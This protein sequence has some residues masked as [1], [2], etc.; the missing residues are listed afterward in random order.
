[1]PRA[2][3][4]KGFVFRVLPAPTIPKGAASAEGASEENWRFCGKYCAKFILKCQS[5]A[6]YSQILGSIPDSLFWHLEKL[7]QF[8]I[9][10]SSHSGRI[11]YEHSL[12]YPH[13]TLIRSVV[14]RPFCLPLVVSIKLRY[15]TSPLFTCS[16]P[17]RK[18]MPLGIALHD[19]MKRLLLVVG[20]GPVTV[21]QV[22]HET[23]ILYQSTMKLV[24]CLFIMSTFPVNWCTLPGLVP[25]AFVCTCAATSLIDDWSKITHASLALSSVL[26]VA[27][28]KVQH[29]LCS[30]SEHFVIS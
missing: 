15:C 5:K 2:S 3:S 1:M 11:R 10:R 9:L 29:Q 19:G 13:P 21:S 14:M 4:H 17:G 12:A 6:H 8:V 26:F 7:T 24:P 25:P 23:S 16:M 20:Y 27:H 18:G 28:S 30:I 22:F